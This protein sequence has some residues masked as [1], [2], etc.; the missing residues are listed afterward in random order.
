MGFIS[1]WHFLIGGAL[2]A[3]MATVA[4]PAPAVNWTPQFLA[5][6]L[7]LSLAGTAAAFLDWFTEAAYSRLD[8]LTAWTMLVPVI[9]IGASLFLPRG[10]PH[11]PRRR[12]ASSWSWPRSGS[13]SPDPPPASGTKASDAAHRGGTIMNCKG[14]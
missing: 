8:L 14:G 12:P 13:C 3:W 9:G 2:P 7:F 11:R 10:T 1:A 6:M 4:E 5:V